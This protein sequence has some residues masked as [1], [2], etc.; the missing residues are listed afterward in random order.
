MLL[1]GSFFDILSVSCEDVQLI[2]NWRAYERILWRN[3]VQVDC[4]ESPQ[5]GRRSDKKVPHVFSN[6]NAGK[7]KEH[8]KE[9]VPTASCDVTQYS[10]LAID[11]SEK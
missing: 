1:G 9:T 6:G 2:I 4:L 5:T 7:I 3:R 10:L 8:K 11:I